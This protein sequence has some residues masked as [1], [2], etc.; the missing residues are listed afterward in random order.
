[1]WATGIFRE[2]RFL[3]IIL[4]IFIFSYALHFHGL[5]HD[6]PRPIDQ[7]YTLTINIV[8][9]GSLIMNDNLEVLSSELCRNDTEK[10]F[11]GVSNYVEEIKT[12]FEYLKKCKLIGHALSL[13]SDG[14]IYP[15]YPPGLSFLAVPFYFIA[16]FLGFGTLIKIASMF[17]LNILLS[18][19]IIFFIFKISELYTTKENAKKIAIIFAFGTIIYT[20]SQT[21]AADVLAA[22]LVITS[23]YFFILSTKNKKI[24]YTFLSGFPLGYIFITKPPLLFIPAIIFLAYVYLSIKEKNYKYS[25][26][27]LAGFCI[28][29]FITGL[30][31][32]TA[33]GSFFKTGY[34]SKISMETYL[35]TGEIKTIDESQLFINNPLIQGPI[36]LFAIIF[37]S[38]FLIFSMTNRKPLLENRVVW[39]I[40]L[41][42]LLIFGSFTSP[43]G[44]WCFGARLELFMFPLLSVPLAINFETINK[45]KKK[46][47]W[48]LVVL[49]IIISILGTLNFTMWDI[50]SRFDDIVRNISKL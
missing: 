12:N 42:T 41:L 18:I 33:Y 34:H 36:I 27:F 4:L 5:Q 49:A 37:T 26:F 24:K 1:M 8:E 6:L 28:L 30:Y 29:F 23:F 44:A 45:K 14:N 19:G 16:H 21:F 20:Y 22:F 7:Y 46:I 11:G 31:Y 32:Y 43:F 13:G 15:K 2:Y 47:F 50:W 40:L 10:L 35:K 38:P 3:I 17:F 39:S 48:L 9:K 25:L